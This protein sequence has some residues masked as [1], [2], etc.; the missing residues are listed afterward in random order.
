MPAD[1]SI[2]PNPLSPAAPPPAV[3]A[4]RLV[5]E[6]L[7]GLHVVGWAFDPAAPGQ[8]KLQL[9]CGGQLFEPA[10]RRLPR[11]DV[12]RVLGTAPELPLGF[13]LEWP[14]LRPL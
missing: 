2:T 12:A 14:T 10:V 1:T 13:E 5:V 7:A 6:R 9:V 8:E 3:A 11:A 4:P